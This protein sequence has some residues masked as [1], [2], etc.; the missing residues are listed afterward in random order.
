M[1]RTPEQNKRRS[2]KYNKVKSPRSLYLK[3]KRTKSPRRHSI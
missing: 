2:R 1:P 3:Q